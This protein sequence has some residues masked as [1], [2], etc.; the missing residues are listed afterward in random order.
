MLN[1]LPWHGQSM[2][3]S[4]TAVDRAALVRAVA[5]NA[6]KSPSVGWV[7]TIFWSSKI[8]PPPTG[9]SAVLARRRRPPRARRVAPLGRARASGAAAV[10]SR[11]PAPQAVD[12][13]RQATSADASRSPLCDSSGHLPCVTAN[14]TQVRNS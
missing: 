7:T 3:P 14:R 12:R 8:L 10:V 6:L 1:L 11:H 13:Q 2:T 4:S 9:M 5:L